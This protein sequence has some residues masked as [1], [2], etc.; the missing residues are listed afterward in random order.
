MVVS[1][2]WHQNP[3][4]CTISLNCQLQRYGPE[5]FSQSNGKDRT[6]YRS[7][8][9]ETGFNLTLIL[10]SLDWRRSDR[11][12]CKDK[13]DQLLFNGQGETPKYLDLTRYFSLLKQT[14]KKTSKHDSRPDQRQLQRIQ[15]SAVSN[16][17]YGRLCSTTSIR[18]HPG[19]FG[20][21]L[22]SISQRQA[23][24]GPI[25][26]ATEEKPRSRELL[27]RMQLP[28]LSVHSTRRM[29][30][31]NP[32]MT[33]NDRS[34][35]E[36]TFCQGYNLEKICGRHK[37]PNAEMDVE[38]VCKMCYPRKNRI[39][40]KKHCEQRERREIQAF[41]I[42][43]AVL[44]V[45]IAVAAVMY[46]T[47]IA[48]RPLTKKC[49]MLWRIRTGQI[50]TSPVT[51]SRFSSIFSVESSPTFDPGYFFDSEMESAQS[52][53]DAKRSTAA[54][55]MFQQKVKH[56]LA[57]E[58]R[59]QIQGFFDLESLP[60]SHPK[61]GVSERVPVLPRAS[62]ASSRSYWTDGGRIRVSTGNCESISRDSSDGFGTSHDTRDSTDMPPHYTS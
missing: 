45:T 48:S 21:L 22:S 11:Q 53:C 15:P 54:F 20:Y 40:V 3:N 44:G 12:G 6:N 27:K 25:E 35:C 57:K 29:H 5:D 55:S 62:N 28:R 49:Q 1:G 52:E 4:L 16:G 36:R 59:R 33:A 41:H 2:T 58:P 51:A 61:E 43:C 10:A 60:Q 37:K 50:P 8:K 23:A 56:L 34:E 30:Q 46:L 18:N 26:A 31:V 42:L 17:Q 9:P 32:S 47:R 13:F 38:S 39:L 14:G 7:H 24:Y 19:L